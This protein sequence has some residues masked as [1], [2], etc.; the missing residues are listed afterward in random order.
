MVGIN[1]L[2]DSPS[3]MASDLTEGMKAVALNQEITF[4]LYG[5][6]VLPVDG[7]IFWVRAPLLKQKQFQPSNLVTAMQ[8]SDEDMDPCEIKAKCSLHYTADVRQEEA[9][10]YTANRVVFTTNEEIQDLNDVAAGTM[11]IAEFEGLRFAFSSASMRYRQAGLW[12]YAGF[13]LYADMQTQI[14]DRAQ[15]FSSDLVVSNSL[16]AWL[17]IAGYQPPWSFWGPLPTLFPSFLVPDNEIPPYGAVHIAPESTHALASAPTIDHATSTHIQ[18]AAETVKIT[19]WGNRNNMAQ[20]FVDAVYRYSSDTGLIGIMN[21]P[22][23]RDEK[24]TQAEMRVIAIKK[25]VEVEI[26]YLQHRMRNVATQV[27]KSAIP[28]LY[29]NGKPIDE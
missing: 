1:E 5:R 13:A 26:S 11:W 7:F 18:L 24:R 17:A 10:T 23:I 22:I 25:S 4:R 19:L 15:D 16:P 12:H 9:E 20:D 3:P 2:F 21:M 27:I 29:V 28:N 8:L 6:V 14:I